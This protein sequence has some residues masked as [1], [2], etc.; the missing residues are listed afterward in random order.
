MKDILLINMASATDFHE[1]V[2]DYNPSL[3]VLSLATILELHGHSCAVKDFCYEPMDADVI[4]SFIKAEGIRIVTM[5]T[6]TINVDDALNFAKF[7]KKSVRGIT[8][9]MGGPHITL[10][11]SY[12]YKSRYVDYCLKGEGEA[13]IIEL[14]EGVLS[15]F[16]I[17]RAEQVAG[18]CYYDNRGKVENETPSPI[19][20]LDLLP[21]VNRN[22]AGIE[23]YIDVINISSSRGCPARCIY[24]AGSVLGGRRYRI[25]NIDN[26]V[27]EIIRVKSQLKDKIRLIYFIDD[28]FT[29]VKKRIY[30]Y[31]KLRKLLNLGY[32]WRCES[33]LDVMDEEVLDV[34]SDNGCLAIH[35][36]VESGSQYVLD[37]IQKS[38]NL[39]RAVKLIRYASTKKMLI[40]CYFMIGHY[41][42]TLLTM[43]QTCELIKTLVT[44]CAIDASLH[45]NT[46]YPGTYQ[47]EHM[48]E[49]GIK[50]ISDDFRKFV[51]YKP[52]METDSF[53]IEDQKR[54]YRSVSAYLNRSDFIV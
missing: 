4:A 34:I 40:C 1:D 30:R 11:A 51:G 37:R 17:I 43:E 41:C 38:I 22:L 14:V 5:T 52:I 28:T 42:D 9:I 25:R 19:E 31:V 35:F 24:C 48:E 45:Y 54:M 33:R 16:S 18:V 50:L 26:V 29:V 8:I 21:I 49:L 3:G 20:N 46:P 7:L 2:V 36:G 27:L 15:D 23:R 32:L 12:C 6:Y 47:Y 13:S 39:E 44:E 10:D 53:T